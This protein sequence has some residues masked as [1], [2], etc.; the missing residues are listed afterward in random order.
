MVEFTDVLTR[1]DKEAKNVV[2]VLKILMILRIKREET[3]FLDTG[4]NRR[5]HYNNWNL[6]YQISSYIPVAFHNLSG[7]DAHIFIK[8]LEIQFNK[9]NIWVIAENKEKYIMLRYVNFEPSFKV[10]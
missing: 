1:E 10:R 3:W 4:L 7:Y 6:K 2:S 5:A 9:N 8:G